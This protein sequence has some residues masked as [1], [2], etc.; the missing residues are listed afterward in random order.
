[1]L[2]RETIR[3]VGPQT[4]DY[5]AAFIHAFGDIIGGERF[6]VDTGH[7]K[8][9]S[10]WL[11]VCLDPGM[12]RERVFDTVLPFW[13]IPGDPELIYHIMQLGN[14]LS[15]SERDREAIARRRI[16]VCPHAVVRQDRDPMNSGDT[17]IGTAID[18]EIL[19]DTL[20]HVVKLTDFISLDFHSFEAGDYFRKCKLPHLNITAMTEVEKWL[21]GMVKTIGISLEDIA[22]VALDKG[23]LQRILH[24]ANLLGLDISNQI[25]VLNKER[26]GHN[27]LGESNILYGNPKGRVL[28]II[29][30]IIDTLS[31]IEK[32]SSALADADALAVYVAAVH[33]VL[34]HPAR[35]NICESLD[36]GVLS[37]LAVSDSLPTGAYK[38]QRVGGVSTFSVV[39]TMAEATKLVLNHPIPEI[40]YG[41][42]EDF[43]QSELEF[44][45][46]NVM[47]LQP[48]EVVW[49][50]FA[51]NVGVQMAKAA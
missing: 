49:R 19:A 5:Y 3:V 11:Q 12:N 39:E 15:H 17:Q 7:F 26:T 24:L 6:H 34:S 2:D 27:V 40:L 10:P 4:F 8:D 22:L 43:T 21:K 18:A 23:A 50:Q 47:V 46:R 38:L 25:V 30:D 13:S 31:S 20:A 44:I 37:G 33:G 36:S 45:R 14:A 35:L 41:D 16:G 1:M 28:F 51:A 29:D 42:E 9:Q 32:T 48:K